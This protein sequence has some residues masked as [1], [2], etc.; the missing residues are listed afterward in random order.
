VPNRSRYGHL[1]M[2]SGVYAASERARRRGL[3]RSLPPQPEHRCHTSERGP[4]RATSARGDRPSFTE[5]RR[6][7]EKTA[8]SVHFIAYLLSLHGNN[9]PRVVVGCPRR[10][11][12]AADE[13][14][15]TCSGSSRRGATT[16][17][18]CTQPDA[19]SHRVTSNACAS[20]VRPHGRSPT[21]AR[22]RPAR[23]RQ[24]DTACGEGA[25][26][27]KSRNPLFSN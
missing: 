6:R 17:R 20:R 26:D 2:T 8:R 7:V 19:R 16:T 25:S 5:L 4:A 15:C 24:I 23:T 10:R 3:R 21:C 18:H 27:Q 9:T 14:R 12:S 13:P 22:C 1:R 11:V